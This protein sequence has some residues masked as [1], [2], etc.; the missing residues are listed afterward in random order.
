MRKQRIEYDS[1]VDALVAIA[2]RLSIYETRYR[3][4]SEEFFDKFS[5]GQSEDS[6]DFVEWANDYQNYV[7]IRREIEAHV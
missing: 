6:E 4:T 1:P 5:K 2:K 7:V 3:M